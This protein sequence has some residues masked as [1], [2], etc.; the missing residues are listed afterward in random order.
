MKVKDTIL[1]IH[2][3]QEQNAQFTKENVELKARNEFLQKM[4]NG[5][6]LNNSKLTQERNNAIDE[7]NRIKALGMY[8]FAD[9][10]CNSEELEE[11]GHQLARSLLGHRMTDEELAIDAAENCYVPYSGD[12]F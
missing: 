9:K 7:L 6:K 1:E 2:E 10:Y 12:D 11:A 5:V 4:C 3:L 8:E